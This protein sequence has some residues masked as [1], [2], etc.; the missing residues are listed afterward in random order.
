VVGYD[1]VLSLDAAWKLP[2]DRMTRADSLDDLLRQCDYITIHV[3][4]IKGATHHM[5]NG[6]N[7]KLCRPVR[8]GA[9]ACSKGGRAGSCARL[10]A[11]APR[12]R[13]AQ[14]SLS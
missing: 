7:L 4:Y 3:P 13:D 10:E 6:A 11:A 14:R 1:P 9:G 5:L 8:A 2:G 12:A